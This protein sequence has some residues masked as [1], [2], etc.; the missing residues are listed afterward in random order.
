MK[1]TSGIILALLMSIVNVMMEQNNVSEKLNGKNIRGGPL[2]ILSRCRISEEL[3]YESCKK[4][5]YRYGECVSTPGLLFGGLDCE[6]RE[7]ILAFAKNSIS[8]ITGE[9]L[10]KINYVKDSLVKEAQDIGRIVTPVQ[11]IVS[12]FIEDV[13]NIIDGLS[14]YTF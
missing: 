4:V 7:H 3:C 14:A 6:C 2:G 1:N 12:T 10:P 5:G 13:Q 11:D 9:Y 8:Q